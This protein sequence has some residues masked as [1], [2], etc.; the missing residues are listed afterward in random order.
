MANNQKQFEG[1]LKNIQLI[2]EDLDSLRTSR[3]ANRDRIKKYWKEELKRLV[4]TFE[5]QGSFK[6]GTVVRPIEGDYDLDDGMYLN[7]IGNDPEKWESTA[8]IQGWVCSAVEGATQGNPQKRKRCV[9]IPY[10]GGYHVDVPSYGIDSFNTTR[11]YEKDKQPTDFDES[12]PVALVEWFDE[13]KKSHADLRDLVRFFKGW[14]DHQ[15]GVLTKIKSVAMTI[16]VSERIQSNERY[17]QAV[18]DTA[19]NCANHLRAGGSIS[20]PVAPF[21][22]LTASWSDDERTKIADAFQALADKGTEARDSGTVRAGALIWQKQ[23]G[24]RYPVPDEDA[25]KVLGP[26]IFVKRDIRESQPFA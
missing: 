22:N 10:K 13:R 1:F 25:E 17:D 26:S 23:F 19:Q 15:K 8:M 7:C 16:L 18:I 9:R 11:V 14:R 21:E 5:E 20:K 3:D 4:P 12:N 2:G 6:M 24:S